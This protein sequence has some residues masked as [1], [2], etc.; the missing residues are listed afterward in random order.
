M[1][2][3]DVVSRLKSLEPRLRAHGVASLYIHGSYARD[4][5]RP[6]SDIDILADFAVDQ[7]PSFSRFMDTYHELEDAFPG[8]EIGFA[9]RDSLVPL[10][11]PHIESNAV[12]VF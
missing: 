4:E 5:A 2:L 7:A 11:R 6:S 3:A 9:T 8:T 10:Y 1:N 12:R